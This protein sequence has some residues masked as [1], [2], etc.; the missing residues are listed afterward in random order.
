MRCPDCHGRAWP[1]HPR[2]LA[3]A[4]EEDVDGRATPGHDSGI[5]ESLSTSVGISRD[6]LFD[7]AQPVLAE[8]DLVADEECRRTERA[9]LDRTLR[10][11]RATKRST[12]AKL[13][14][15]FEAVIV[16]RMN[17]EW[18]ITKPAGRAKERRLDQ[19][20]A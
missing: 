19:M 15:L 13:D 14:R 20:F 6:R 8:E 2:L 4:D 5:D 12:P 1:G 10:G 11:R 3:D 17:G 16:I 9:A 18:P 7:I